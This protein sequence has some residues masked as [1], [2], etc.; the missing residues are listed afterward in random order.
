[1]CVHVAYLLGSGSGRA[2]RLLVRGAIE[3]I[4]I[5]SGYVCRLQLL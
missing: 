2:L 4:S 1:M 5:A 3:I